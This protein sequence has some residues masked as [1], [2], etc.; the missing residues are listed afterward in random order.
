MSRSQT[1]SGAAIADDADVWILNSC[2]VK[3]PSG[4]SELWF[5]T[6]SLAGEIGWSSPDWTEDNFVNAIKEA[7]TKG[8]HVVVAGCVPQAQPRD[9]RFAT[10]S[11]IGVSHLCVCVYVCVC[12]RVCVCVCVCVNSA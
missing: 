10:Y 12:V 3:T 1:H 6:L 4:A 11:I 5:I 8:K 9:T 7:H 2:T